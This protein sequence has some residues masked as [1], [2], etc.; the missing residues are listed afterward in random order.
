MAKPQKYKTV[1]K[2]LRSMG[3]TLQRQGKGSHEVWAG[4]DGGRLVIPHHREI[5][6]GVVADIIKKVPNTPKNWK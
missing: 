6:A 4:P 5:S 1:V 3:W 2:F